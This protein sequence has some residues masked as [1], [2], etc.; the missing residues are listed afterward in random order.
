MA[1]VFLCGGGK[2][3]IMVIPKTRWEKHGLTVKRPPGNQEVRGS[4]PTTVHV[5]KNESYRWKAPCTECA[6][7]GQQD[8]SG[9]PADQSE[10]GL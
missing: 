6:P 10:L 2:K 4:K 5:G 1:A 9:R 3:S 8:L 7:I